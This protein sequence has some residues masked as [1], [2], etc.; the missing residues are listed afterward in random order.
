MAASISCEYRKASQTGHCD[1]DQPT[2]DMLIS[3]FAPA[4]RSLLRAE[5][6]KASTST[7]CTSS[8]SSSL[9][10]P[11]IYFPF[12]SPCSPSSSDMSSPTHSPRSSTP[13]PP[14]V[15]PLLLRPPPPVIPSCW[16]IPDELL[17]LCWY[18]LTVEEV[19]TGPG[20][21][22]RRSVRLLGLSS[23]LTRLI[24][25]Q[26]QQQQQPSSSS[27]YS[28][29]SSPSASLPLSSL[30][31]AGN[32]TP[33][34]SVLPLLPEL[35]L[36]ASLKMH[37]SRHNIGFTSSTSCPSLLPATAAPP[38]LSQGLDD[39]LYPAGVQQLILSRLPPLQTL[40]ALL[41][42]V[43]NQVVHIEFR[44][45]PPA[46]AAFPEPAP[47]GAPG[48]NPLVTALSPLTEMPCLTHLSLWR[49]KKLS[50]DALDEVIS[51]V[52]SRCL[53]LTSLDLAN[54]RVTN[55]GLAALQP[56]TNLQRLDISGCHKVSRSGVLTLPPTLK[57]VFVQ[58]PFE[59]PLPSLAPTLPD[60]KFDMHYY[61]ACS[62]CRKVRPTGKSGYRWPRCAGCHRAGYCD[63]DCQRAHWNTHRIDCP[64]AFGGPFFRGTRRRLLDAN[65]KF[66]CP[67]HIVPDTYTA[68][69]PTPPLPL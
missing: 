39:G 27:H 7:V 61:S 11:S 25:Q 3:E 28:S 1:P 2:T 14:C 49:W 53:H 38:P 58:L 65:G 47:W 67:P 31:Y 52:V 69:Q 44:A 60:L 51:K 35:S 26:Q 22:D 40:R 29:H 5:A 20:M 56:L 13:S 15:P 48:T 23:S 43:K 64:I 54:C 9:C 4:R 68:D 33:R 42:A 8:C 59:R 50:N 57:H 24:Q 41:T 10:P 12:S 36:S 21:V 32:S 6:V 63:K 66:P 62:F 17:C 45:N 37:F 18:Y 46:Y 19:V 34:A 55:R 16:A 30:P